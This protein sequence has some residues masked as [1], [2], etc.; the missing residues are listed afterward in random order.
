M[1]SAIQCIKGIPELR[2][3]FLIDEYLDHLNLESKLGAGGILAV[4]WG[5]LMKQMHNTT[6]RCLT[7]K[8]FRTILANKYIEV[9]ISLLK[10]IITSME[11]QANKM[12]WS[13]LVTFLTICMK[14]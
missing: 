10:F 13:A 4:E 2:S 5:N 1:N 14:T 7:P 6:K 9:N 11:R 8:K 12:L 3:Y